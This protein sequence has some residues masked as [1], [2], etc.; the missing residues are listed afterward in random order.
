M[1]VSKTPLDELRIERG[2][3]REP[4]SKTWM[5]VAAAAIVLVLGLVAMVWHSCSGAIV[6]RTAV[7]E[8]SV[9]AAATA[10]SGRC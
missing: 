9:V 3:A 4:E 8:E 10:A 2:A 6:V 5:A 7:A 1:S